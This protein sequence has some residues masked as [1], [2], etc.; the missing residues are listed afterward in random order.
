MDEQWFEHLRADAT[1]MELHRGRADDGQ[2]HGSSWTMHVMKAI[3]K[4]SGE[5]QNDLCGKRLVGNFLKA[6]PH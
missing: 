5:V 2:G 4:C 3:L 6:T 1:A